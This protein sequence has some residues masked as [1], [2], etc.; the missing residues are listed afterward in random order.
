MVTA[1]GVATEHVVKL[2]GAEGSFRLPAAGATRLAVDPDCHLFRHLDPAEIEPTISQV[3][4]NDRRAYVVDAPPPALAEAALAFARA[5]AEDDSAATVDGALPDDGRALV[6]VNP[7]AALLARFPAPGLTISG[8][9][10]FLEGKRYDLAATD[11][12][13]AA[14]DP[15]RPGATALVV[16]CTAPERLPGL[17]D[18]VSHYGKY[19]WLALPAGQ[20]RP[21]RGNWP[22]GPSPLLAGR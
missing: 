9:Y 8:R 4:G 14:A 18:R 7:G 6:L 21:E 12:V 5:F 1:G 17:A 11:L 19:S 3:Y 13:Y 20:G 22:A 2:A 15:R 16:L 10:A